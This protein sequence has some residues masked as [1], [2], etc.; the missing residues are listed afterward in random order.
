MNRLLTTRPT[1]NL[2]RTSLSRGSVLL[3]VL[4][5]VA[6]MALCTASF[7]LSMENEHRATRFSGRQQQVRYLA[8][9]GAAY[10]LAFLGQSYDDIDR[11]GGLYDN[12][13][14]MQSLLVAENTSAFNQG[15]FTVLAPMIEQ[16]LYSM[17]R[18]GLENE[19]AKLNLN[20]IL[21]GDS[22]EKPTARDRLL[23]LPGMQPPV[24]DAILDWLDA[25]K[26]PRDFGVE[27]TYYLSLNPPYEPRNGAIVSLDELLLVRGVTPEL[28]YG[29][30]INRNYLVDDNEQARGNAAQADHLA[31]ELDRGWAAYLTIHSLQEAATADGSD[32]REWPGFEKTARPIASRSRR[33]GCKFYYLVSSISTRR[34]RRFAA[35]IRP[36]CCADGFREKSGEHDQHFLGFNRRTLA[37]PRGRR[38]AGT[39][40][41]IALGERRR[42]IVGRF[43]RTLGSG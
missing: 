43:F 33:A 7:L 24:A 34:R 21:A 30:D 6:V 28:L 13:S 42:D 16:G 3:L 29:S 9:S 8:D 23:E 35:D 12:P 18:Y 41:P 1:P 20:S 10:L 11:Q 19:S 37:N 39:N 25:D 14:A 27:E 36:L 2:R 15:R 5:A 40:Y 4:V 26:L 38:R 22:P 17:A 32:Q 31:G